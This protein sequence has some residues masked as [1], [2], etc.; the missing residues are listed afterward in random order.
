[1]AWRSVLER[2]KPAQELQLLFAIERNRR[3]AVGAGYHRAQNQDQNLVQRIGDLR[4]LARVFNSFELSNERW[5]SKC[6]RKSGVVRSFRVCDM[7]ISK[8]QGRSTPLIQ[9]NARLSAT[10]SV[11]CPGS[12]RQAS[13]SAPT[14]KLAETPT[15][16]H[17]NVIPDAPFLVIPQVSSERREYAPIG[18]LEPPTIPSNKLRLLANATLADFALLTSAMHMAWLR[19][20]T[21]RMKS[22][23]I[24]SV[25]VVYNT[26]PTPPGLASG[27]ADLSKLEPLAEL[28]QT[29]LDARAAR[30]DATLADLYDPD[31]M[32]PTL[33]RAHARLERAVDRL[34]P[35]TKSFPPS[36]NGSNTCSCCMTGCKCRLR[37][38]RRTEDDEEGA[39]MTCQGKRL[40][41]SRMAGYC[42]GADRL[43]PGFGHKGTPCAWQNPAGGGPDA[44]RSKQSDCRDIAVTLKGLFRP[45]FPRETHA[46]Q[47]RTSN[48]LQ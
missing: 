28:A 48:A 13:K 38:R 44:A 17:V 32:P 3:P 23:Y 29:V 8:K 42:V 1:M 27:E 14:R 36:A 47:R 46:V 37:H 4:R 2:Q 34:L 30:R 19:T 7:R 18:W 9:K 12:Y 45:G 24:Y 35:R 25:G 15:L 6:V 11:D 43:P 10:Y 20:V 33:R 41:H 5:R 22:D 21:G 26:F 40:Y 16:Y 31:L 39:G